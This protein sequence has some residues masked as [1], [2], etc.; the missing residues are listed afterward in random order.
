MPAARA[1]PPQRAV[2]AAQG[3]GPRLRG[4]QPGSRATRAG[5]SRSR[6]PGVRRGPR[7][8][9]GPGDRDRP[10]AQRAERRRGPAAT[11]RAA[12]RPAA[13]CPR[14][15]WRPATC[16][17]ATATPAA[18]STTSTPL[19]GRPARG[20][21]GRRDGPGCR[22]RRPRWRRCGPRSGRWSRSSPDP[23]TVMVALDRL[24]DQYDFQQLVTLVYAVL[25][26]DRDELV[27]VNAGHPPPLVLGTP[28]G[29]VERGRG[30]SRG[31]CSA[32]G[33]R[34]APRSGCRSA[35]AT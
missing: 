35:R 34:T 28:D 30:G 29:S 25:D 10:A 17:P 9:G 7:P 26:P 27:V 1:Q 21:R 13:T 31:C 32:P 16:R 33:A 12:C 24:F 4:D 14:G 8:A 3:A 22:R 23:A 20:V 18:T 6:R 2:G 19:D 11:G 5:A 15:R